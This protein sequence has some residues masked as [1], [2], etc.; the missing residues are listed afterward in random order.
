MAMNLHMGLATNVKKNAKMKP[1]TMLQMGMKYCRSAGHSGDQI[2]AVAVGDG[3]HSTA[4]PRISQ[5][6]EAEMSR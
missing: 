2:K 3:H 6:D 5:S 4:L 1:N